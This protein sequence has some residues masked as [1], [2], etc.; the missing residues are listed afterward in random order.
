MIEPGKRR[1]PSQVRNMMETR[2]RKLAASYGVEVQLDSAREMQ[3]I[4]ADFIKD[5]EAMRKAEA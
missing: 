1:T 5:R 4:L 2:V 3:I